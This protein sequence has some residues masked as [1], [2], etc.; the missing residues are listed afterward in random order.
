MAEAFT[1]P[2]TCE[3]IKEPVSSKYGH[4]FEKEAVENWV[5]KH[6]TCP[7]TQKPLELSDLFPQYA[8]KAAIKQYLL[9]QENINAGKVK[10]DVKEESKEPVVDEVKM[11]NMTMG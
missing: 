2:I 6:H 8:V 3:I 11:M 10:I 4:L 7:L 1:C 5:K 9:L